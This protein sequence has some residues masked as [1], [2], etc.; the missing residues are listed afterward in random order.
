MTIDL[1]LLFSLY[2]LWTNYFVV[3]GVLWE[4]EKAAIRF[5]EEHDPAFLRQFR[6]C[7]EESNRNEKVRQYEELVGLAMAP[8]G[9]KWNA[10]ETSV[11]LDAQGED[12]V[13]YEVLTYWEQL[14][15]EQNDTK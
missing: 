5:L 15:S 1:R 3:R 7:L 6:E 14:L 10:G 9:A 2:Q 13:T 11:L 12:G 4:G 8:I